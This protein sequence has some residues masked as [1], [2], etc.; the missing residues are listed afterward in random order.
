MKKS[1]CFKKAQIAVLNTICIDVW[2]KL[3]I[4]RALMSE[5]D[6]QKMVEEREEKE[7]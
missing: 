4:L 6:I 2:D 7:I 5:E 3:E 1:E